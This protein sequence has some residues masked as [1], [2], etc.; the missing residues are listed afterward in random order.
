MEFAELRRDEDSARSGGKI[1]TTVLQFGHF[2]VYME[3]VN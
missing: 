2:A 1:N 3:W